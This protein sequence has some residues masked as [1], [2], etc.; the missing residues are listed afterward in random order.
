MHGKRRD[1]CAECMNFN[2]FL[3]AVPGQSLSLSE[4]WIIRIDNTTRSN[5]LVPQLSALWALS[6]GDVEAQEESLGEVR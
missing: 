4:P 2:H 1:L 3:S 5:P 6:L